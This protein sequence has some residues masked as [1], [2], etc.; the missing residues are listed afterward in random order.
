MKPKYIVEIGVI[1]TAPSYVVVM[2]DLANLASN[3]LLW[4]LSII[5]RKVA[6]K[7]ANEY[8]RT[9]LIYQKTSFFSRNK[10][11]YEEKIPGKLGEQEVSK[12]LY[13]LEKSAESGTIEELLGFLLNGEK[14]I[15]NERS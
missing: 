14:Q 7:S 4:I 3:I 2:D 12:K 8:Y 1:R 11:I 10:L 6:D 15:F 9:V 13:Y 5:T